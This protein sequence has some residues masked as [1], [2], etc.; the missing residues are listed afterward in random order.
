MY[1]ISDFICGLSNCFGKMYEILRN[2]EYIFIKRNGI[3]S[4]SIIGKVCIQEL[5]EIINTFSEEDSFNDNYLYNRTHLEVAVKMPENYRIPSIR[6]LDKEQFRIEE[7]G[8]LFSISTASSNY[9]FALISNYFK[10]NSDVDIPYIS[11]LYHN[12]AINSFDDLTK[13]FRILTVKIYSPAD[14]SFSEYKKILNSYLFNISYNNNYVF[15][16]RNFKDERSHYIDRIKRKGQLFP[17]RSYN[18]EL[19][20]YYYQGVSSDMPFTQYLA[21]YH[22]LEFFFQ[23]VSEQVAFEAIEEFITR[24][25]FSP[26]HKEDIKNFYKKIKTIMKEQKDDGVWNERNSLLLC[27]KKYVPDLEELKETII[28]ISENSVDY[29]QNNTVPFADGENI[30]SFYTTTDKIYSD[31]RN[32][33]YAVRNSIV[34]SKDGE[35]LRYEPF[36][37]D[38]ELTKEIP[39]IRAIAEEII[40]NSAKPTELRH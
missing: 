26:H 37:H 40:I 23:S 20:R 35:R 15:S 7:Y 32:R 4:D 39:L 1:N 5:E 33:V 36:K 17:Y 10:E 22:I 38:K 25:S 18:P 13:A 27:L 12:E 8:Y 11:R 14:Y 30:I 2:D 9:L 31:I 34:H 16:V 29:Y 21:F 24:P 6:F 19:I 28:S 3:S